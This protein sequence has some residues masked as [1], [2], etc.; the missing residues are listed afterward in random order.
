MSVESV[1]VSLRGRSNLQSTTEVMMEL[2]GPVEMAEL[3]S[4][5]D[6]GR[7][8]RADKGAEVIGV[9]MESGDPWP[10]WCAVVEDEW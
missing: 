8:T 4:V 9:A 7:V 2:G 6:Q 3:L 10:K 1:R 5:D